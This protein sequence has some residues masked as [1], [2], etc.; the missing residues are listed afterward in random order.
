MTLLYRFAAMYAMGRPVA[1]NVR[2]SRAAP[3]DVIELSEWCVK[4]NSL[5]LYLWLSSRFPN[6]FVEKDLCAEQK[7][8]AISVI[9][10]SLHYPVLQQKFSHS[11]DYQKVRQVMMM[12]A[13]DSLPPIAYGSIRQKTR[14]ELLKLSKE[15]WFHF[16]RQTE[17]LEAAGVDL[18]SEEA[19]LGSRRV[20][21]GGAGR[22][23]LG[24]GRGGLGAATGGG[25]G[26]GADWKRKGRREDDFQPKDLMSLINLQN[27]SDDVEDGSQGG[28]GAEEDSVSGGVSSSSMNLSVP[29]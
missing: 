10:N 15:D 23:G 3:R 9:E 8:H 20:N 17:E 7:A 19:Q 1:L 4:H 24:A 27:G 21:K 14:E 6:Y 29:T 12:E 16:P 2:L 26:R 18:A 13:P 5:D 11:I 22:G 25:G 28:S